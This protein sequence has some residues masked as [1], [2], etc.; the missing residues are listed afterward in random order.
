[1]GEEGAIL[2]LG[3]EG[4]LVE[5]RYHVGGLAG[6]NEGTLSGCH[7]TGEVIGGSNVGGVAGYNKG[8]LSECHAAG[9]VTGGWIAGGVAGYNEGT[10]SGC[11]ATGKV[12][13]DRR[14]GG[15]AGYN[16]GTLSECY[17]TGKVSGGRKCGG[18]VGYN[19]G[20][21][22]GCY[23]TGEVTGGSNVGGLAGY[24]EGTV[25][26]C[27]ATGEVS[28]NA[29]VGGLVGYNESKVSGC[30]ATGEVS[31]ELDVG[32][33]VGRNWGGTLSECYAM[34]EVG[35]ESN[36][37]GVVGRTWGGTLS[38]CY[39]AG[40]VSGKE[41]VGGVV[42]YNFRGTVSASYWD[43]Q[44]TGQETS[45]G[46]EG[47][48]TAEMIYPYA[49]GT[50]I[51]WDF[52]DIWVEDADG[53]RN[54]G[55]PYLYAVPPEI[56]IAIVSPMRSGSIVEG[57]SLRFAA[58]GVAE[59]WH[60]DFGD[61]RTSDRKQPGLIRFDEPGG[62]AVEL[63][64]MSQDGEW[65][66]ADVRDIEVVPDPGPLPDLEVTE[67][68]VPDDLLPGQPAEIGYSVRNAGEAPVADIE[69][70]DALYLSYDAYPDASDVRLEEIGISDDLGAGETYHGSFSIVPPWIEKSSFHLIVSAD[71]EWKILD[72]QRLNNKHAEPAEVEVAAIKPDASAAV[73][74]PA[75]AVTRYYRIEAQAGI[76]PLLALDSPLTGLDV[77]A[78]LGQLPTP[79]I[80]DF[81]M[82]GDELLIPAAEDGV[83][84]IL[85]HGPDMSQPGEFSLEYDTEK[86]KLLSA[87]P[88]PQ[89]AF[90]PITLELSGAGFE[91]PVVVELLAEDGTAYEAE[92]ATVDSYTRATATIPA[93][94]VQVGVYSVRATRPDGE[95]DE[96]A[97]ALDV[98]EKII[99]EQG[100]LA[101]DETWAGMVEVQGDVTVPDGITLDILPGARLKF[102][103][104]A[105]L[106]VAGLLDAQG[107]A[108]N[109]VRFA[110][111][112]DMDPEQEAGPG[113]WTG[114]VVRGTGHAILE[115]FEIRYAVT[116]VN[117]NNQGAR[118]DLANGVI[119]DCSQ[120]GIYTFAQFA[121]IDA[122]NCVIANCGYN[123]VFARADSSV[124]LRNSTLTGC[125]FSGSG[126]RAAAIHHGASKLTLDNCIIAF[127]CNG[128]HHSGDVPEVTI[129]RT[130]FYN[131][132]GQEYI[133]PR[134]E[135]ED[136]LEQDGNINADPLFVDREAGDYE[137]AE[138]S[139]AIDAAAAQY[140]P[141]TD[142]LDRKHFDDNGVPNRGTGSPAY[143]DIG[144]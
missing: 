83:W 89:T 118:V 72:R 44:T 85:V 135:N 8:M 12:S 142:I 10:L 36:V 106:E 33:V 55:Y 76:N 91:A 35:G 64:V 99:V 18:V 86:F 82:D 129:R 144:A 92:S 6:Y 1:M 38:E 119:R 133:N 26:G 4:A 130:L 77:Y 117:A 80:H 101:E 2:N 79:Y 68:H 114:L 93:E 103:S 90:A 94:T 126:M 78:R 107:T 48:T 70:T 136:F 17:A 59:A 73:S 24:N 112:K 41:A 42:G 138:H 11:H 75:G 121:E 29:H 98:I 56:P 127:N 120:Y 19:E 47:R 32:G 74:F 71:D 125:G 23:A 5:G 25:S 28:G 140:A 115:N 30:Y 116:G 60:W 39:A 13:G 105:C 122:E 67:V 50:Y 14:C 15:V 65:T 16:E 9:E 54:G 131:P 102:A 128:I 137:L 100:A 51:G 61:G 34:G 27:Y 31:G 40:A 97:N 62:R 110:S 20:T 109:P 69:W 113:D 49:A 81:R 96:L 57:D 139:P 22:S 21:V 7:A 87:S 66:V 143:V 134:P 3:V 46:G 84:Y 52:K 63:T 43:T 108:D 132:A 53:S 104:G 95:S 124:H 58:G 111:V 141:D 123:A 45:N 88:T 37:G